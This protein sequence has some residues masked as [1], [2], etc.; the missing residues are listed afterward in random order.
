LKHGTT[1]REVRA[2]TQA[3]AQQQLAECGI[4]LE[5][6]GYSS[7]VFFSSYG[8]GGP[9]DTGQLDIGEWSGTTNFPDPDSTRWL[10][11]EIPTDEFPD[12]NNSQKLCDE[13]LDGLFQ[14][15]AAQVDF[16]QRQETLWEI[17]NYIL[18]NVI[19]LG[20]WQDPDSFAVSGRL[21]NVKISGATPFFNIAEWDL[22]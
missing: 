19:W 1:T 2:D 4:E 16:G 3:V 11:S 18:D 8:E 21:K 13:K 6:I 22:E 12:G 17:G 14:K 15:Q 9:F 7:D 10:C 20:V 5:I